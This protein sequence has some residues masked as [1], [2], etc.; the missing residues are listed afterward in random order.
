ML[1]ISIDCTVR[2]CFSGKAA[3]EMVLYKKR[4]GERYA[5]EF[6]ECKKMVFYAGKLWIYAQGARKRIKNM[7]EKCGRELFCKR[8]T[9]SGYWLRSGQGGICF[10]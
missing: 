7:G 8:I 9:H 5:G 2:D 6:G 10:I 1:Y 3:G 4:E